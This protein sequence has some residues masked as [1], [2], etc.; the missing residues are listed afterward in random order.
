M[1]R[2]HVPS[3]RVFTE[4]ADALLCTTELPCALCGKRR[5]EHRGPR[6]HCPPLP[7]MT[8]ERPWRR[9]RC[10]FCGRKLFF[11]DVEL[12]I[13]HEVPQCERF[14]QVCGSFGTTQFLEV[15]T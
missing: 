10:R 13:A 8:F 12:K 4:R 15:V 2:E 5:S 11:N 14:A 1:N 9:S 6:E 7:A 3:R